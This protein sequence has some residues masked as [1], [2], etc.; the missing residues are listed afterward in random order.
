MKERQRE[1][2][3]GKGE[4][5]VAGSRLCSGRGGAREDVKNMDEIDKLGMRN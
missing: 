5:F 3:D 2:F 1:Y 4:G